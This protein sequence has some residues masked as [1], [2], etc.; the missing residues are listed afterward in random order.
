MIQHF[1]LQ[2]KYSGFILVDILFF[3]VVIA[4]TMAAFH[5]ESRRTFVGILCASFTV[6]MYAS[7][8]TVV[9]S[10]IC[11]PVKLPV[12]LNPRVLVYELIRMI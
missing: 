9:V 2:V 3:G 7:P 5:E 10:H 1:D 8:L 6:I 11:V 4:V 12:L